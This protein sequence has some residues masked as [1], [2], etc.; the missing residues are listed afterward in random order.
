MN[1]VSIVVPAY[2]PGAFLRTTLDSVIAQT[3]SDW[4]CLVIDDGSREDLSYVDSLHPQIRRLRQENRGLPVARNV[5]LAASQSE[6]IAF[7][8]ADDVWLP[9]KLAAQLQVLAGAPGLA[10]CH[11]A[12]DIIDENGVYV[13][14]GFGRET[15]DYLALLKQSSVCV[16][17]VMVRRECLS[18]AG[19]FDPVRRACEDYDMWL[20]LARFYDMGWVPTVQAQYRVHSNNMSGDPQLM[21]QE[22]GSVLQRHL[23]LARAR[24]DRRATQIILASLR[25]TR[26]GWGCKAYDKSRACLKRRDLSGFARNLRIAFALAP[27]YT[28]RTLAKSLTGSYKR[29]ES[30]DFESEGL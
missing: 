28:A 14:P 11:T 20:N 5:G 2:N 30:A 9:T 18:V 24:G 6:Y 7:V 21:A 1:L 19:G 12:F 4:E 25:H 16:S 15:K 22:V 3:F 13:E 26:I 17:T 8:D 29:S 23:V 27:R 10:M